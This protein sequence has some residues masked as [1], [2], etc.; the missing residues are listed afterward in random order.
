MP[1]TEPVHV[2]GGWESPSAISCKARLSSN[3]L[4][5]FSFSSSDCVVG[6]S[7]STSG[8]CSFLGTLSGWS[9]SSE[10]SLDSMVSCTG[11]STSL[12]ALASSSSSGTEM[13][14]E[15]SCSESDVNVGVSSSTRSMFARGFYNVRQSL[16]FFLKSN[17]ILTT[18]SWLIF[19]RDERYL[20]DIP[21]TLATKPPKPQSL[22]KCVISS[23]QYFIKFKGDGNK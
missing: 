22:L 19:V 5:R 20:T 1:K 3:P 12:D 21:S 18:S 23:L 15:C 8:D 4:S 14:L 16:R 13:S 11:S 6:P 17:D 7:S 2:P 9:P 10:S